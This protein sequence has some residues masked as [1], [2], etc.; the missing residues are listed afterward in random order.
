MHIE[1]APADVAKIAALGIGG[2]A[3]DAEGKTPLPAVIES[4]LREL[5]CDHISP[6]VTPYIHGNMNL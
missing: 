1:A 5:G 4:A 6:E 2:N 3:V